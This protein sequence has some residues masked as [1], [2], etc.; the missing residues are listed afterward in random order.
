MQRWRKEWL[1]AHVSY[2]PGYAWQKILEREARNPLLKVRIVG[3]LIRTHIFYLSVAIL[4]LTASQVKEDERL[5]QKG[6]GDVFR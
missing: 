6:E 3:L 4:I 2:A 5:H 1:A